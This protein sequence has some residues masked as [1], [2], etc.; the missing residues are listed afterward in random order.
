[1]D[2]YLEGRFA[3]IES[4][5]AHPV[6]T[7]EIDCA[8]VDIASLLSDYYALL[9]RCI[10]IFGWQKLRSTLSCVPAHGQGDAA[11]RGTA[12]CTAKCDYDQQVWMR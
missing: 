12:S 4:L 7:Y 2:V 1:M 5:T 6:F 3:G 11:S 8:S 10:Y 9:S